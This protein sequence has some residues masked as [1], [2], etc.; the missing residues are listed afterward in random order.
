MQSRDHTIK[1]LREANTRLELENIRLTA[2]IED[3]TQSVKTLRSERS[4][5]AKTAA[6]LHDYIETI[7]EEQRRETA[8]SD[9][10]HTEQFLEIKR[11]KVLL[12]KEILENADD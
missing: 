3:A 4:E 11:W 1:D 8:V 6:D 2:D 7:R 9:K 10:V 5:Y 12:A